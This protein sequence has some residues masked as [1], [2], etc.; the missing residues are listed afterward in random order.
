MLVFFDLVI[1]SNVLEHMTHPLRR[2]E[3]MSRLIVPD[4]YLFVEVPNE[5]P[6]LQETGRHMPQHITFFTKE[7]FTLL[8]ETHGAFEIIDLRT[9]G[10]PLRELID[11]TEKFHHFD[12]LET[13]DG[14]VIRALLKNVKPT[15][16][17]TPIV[18]DPEDCFRTIQRNS[19][20]LCMLAD[21]VRQ[22]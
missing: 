7:T 19:D 8:V 20:T 2:M 10:I 17:L 14:W 13:P 1:F 16:E 22:V 3:E 5:A 15:V 6:F 4:G 11:G 9:C 21:R 12:R 18:L